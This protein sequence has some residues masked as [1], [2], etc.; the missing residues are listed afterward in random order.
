MRSTDET[1]NDWRVALPEL[2]GRRI[3]LR[4]PRAGDAPSLFSLL[5]TEEVS[6]FISPPPASVEA[7]ERY[8]AWSQRQRA[9]GLY[10]CFAVVPRGADTPIGLVHV[11]ALGPG[12]G[13][14]DWGFAIGSEFWGKGIF[15][16][17]AELVLDFAFEVLHTHRLEARAAV[18][19]ARGNGALRKLG[20][21]REGLLRH[22]FFRDGDYLDQVL[23][24]I[25]AEDWRRRQQDTLAWRSSVVH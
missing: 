1:M 24:S 13:T 22:A 10:V 5:S 25:L 2:E 23:W 12:F 21:E 7:F 15:S 19:N 11:R 4:E 9:A 3:T 16:E 14:A 8:I 17:A 20:A 18:C 6:R